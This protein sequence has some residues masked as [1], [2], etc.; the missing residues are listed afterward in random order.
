MGAK[1]AFAGVCTLDREYFP[2]SLIHAPNAANHYAAPSRTFRLQRSG[3][4]E[5]SGGAWGQSMHKCDDGS[6]AVR[7]RETNK[8]DALGAVAITEVGVALAPSEPRSLRPPDRL[9]AVKSN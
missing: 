1:F 5:I 3:V 7:S 6:A 8:S 9:V 4:P 2:C